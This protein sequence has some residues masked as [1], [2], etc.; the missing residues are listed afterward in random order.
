MHSHRRNARG[1]RGWRNGHYYD[2]QG[3]TKIAFF[4]AFPLVAKA[5][6][7]TGLPTTTALLIVAHLFLIASFLLLWRYTKS[8]WTLLAFAF[9]PPTFFFRMA[10]TESMFFFLALLTPYGISGIEIRG[11]PLR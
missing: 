3:E 8:E 2:A 11:S 7:L 6:A 1:D 4:P 9:W 10:Y 5:L